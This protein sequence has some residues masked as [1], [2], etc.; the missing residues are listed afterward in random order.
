MTDIRTKPKT[1]YE[2]LSWRTGMGGMGGGLSG[3]SR[4][5]LPEWLFSVF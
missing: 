3:E 4:K 2:R 5:A 1:C